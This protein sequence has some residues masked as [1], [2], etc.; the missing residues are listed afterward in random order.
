MRLALLAL[1]ALLLGAEGHELH[2]TVYGAYV[3]DCRRSSSILAGTDL[4]RSD[5]LLD[6][7]A[8]WRP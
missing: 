3:R 5:H 2:E 1:L 7:Y 4:L 8:R 6:I